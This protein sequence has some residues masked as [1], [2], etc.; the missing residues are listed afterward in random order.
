MITAALIWLNFW[1][2]QSARYT[3]R[4][5]EV[6]VLRTAIWLG[7]CN[8]WLCKVLYKRFTRL[9]VVTQ[10]HSLVLRHNQK[11]TSF[12]IHPDSGLVPFYA[13]KPR[14][15][16]C[17]GFV[18]RCRVHS[19]TFYLRDTERNRARQFFALLIASTISL[20]AKEKP[21][22][23]AFFQDVNFTANQYSETLDLNLLS[24][25]SHPQFLRWSGKSRCEI[26]RDRD[27]AARH[28]HR[29][30][31]SGSRRGRARQRR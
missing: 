15:I 30:R 24:G 31:L 1:T 5:L 17:V 25:R 16:W 20:T 14:Q 10:T 26:L 8:L 29:E 12:R 13:H 23:N 22:T 4:F 6:S 3:Y 7:S 19:P 2:S 28:F 9:F 21:R 11:G 18:V 27:I